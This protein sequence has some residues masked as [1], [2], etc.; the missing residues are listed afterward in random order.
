MPISRPC[1]DCGALTSKTRCAQCRSAR[2]KVTHGDTYYR[3]NEWKRLSREARA[4]HGTDCT[5][6]GSNHRVQAHHVVHRNEGGSDTLD[7]LV[8]LC[9][10]CHRRTHAD[11][12]L[13]VIVKSIRGN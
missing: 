7:N 10:S 5:L 4:L 1:L 3:T 8:M 6:C 12:S 2:N 9:A 11:E 13:D